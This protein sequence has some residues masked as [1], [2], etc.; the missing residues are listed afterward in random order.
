M[1]MDDVNGWLIAGG[2]SQIPH[3]STWR[4]D[5][6]QAGARCGKYFQGVELAPNPVLLGGQ[7]VAHSPGAADSRLRGRRGVAELHLSFQAGTF[8]F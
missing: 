7:T 5:A 3:R 8:F 6:I 2:V 1:E 4:S